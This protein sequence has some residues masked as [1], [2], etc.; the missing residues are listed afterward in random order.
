M[1]FVGGKEEKEEKKKK[2]VRSRTRYWREGREG[3]WVRVWV[4]SSRH[5]GGGGEGPSLSPLPLT[6]L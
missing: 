2:G 3:V 1:E 5:T 6:R 4:S